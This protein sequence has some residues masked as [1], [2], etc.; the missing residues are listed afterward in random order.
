MSKAHPKSKSKTKAVIS[1]YRPKRPSLFGPPLLLVGED[2]AEYDELHAAI[3]AAV[4]PVDTV[5]EMFV[6]DAV[7]SEWEVLRWR[8]LKSSLIRVYQ[9][10]ALEK[11]LSKELHYRLYAKDF[12]AELASA[13]KNILPEDQADTA[14][15]LSDACARHEPV[16]NGRVNKILDASKLDLDDILDSA[17]H[18]KAEELAKKYGRREPDVVKLVDEILAGASVGIDE[19]MAE[20]LVER[21][22]TIEHID[23][24]AAIAENRRNTTLGEIDRRRT[25]LGEALRRNIK[26]VEDA[27]FQV[28][29]PTSAKRKTAA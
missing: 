4:N 23:R 20:E 18:R 16:A 27:E 8:R 15:Q 7:A 12:A 17:Q 25:V 24:L 28:V 6:A 22:D 21:L 10:K 14:E 26:E 3:R 2:A 19:L 11:F 29:E 13:L 9:I 5:D 1:R